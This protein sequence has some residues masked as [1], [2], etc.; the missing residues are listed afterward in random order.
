MAVIN[1]TMKK[2]NYIQ[3]IEEKFLPQVPI[4]FPGG[5]SIFQQD[6]APCHKAKDTLDYFNAS[7]L[8]VI[9]WPPYSPD[10]NPIENL[11]G[12]AKKKVCK[13]SYANGAQLER[14]FRELWSIDDNIAAACRSLSRSMPQRIAQCIKNRGG[15]LKY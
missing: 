5:G 10:L 9:D 7:G 2:Q 13:K 15:P 12:I 14:A 3:T 8:N 4:W 1:G 6:N 11:W